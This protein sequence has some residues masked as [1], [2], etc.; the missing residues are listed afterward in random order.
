[1]AVLQDKLIPEAAESSSSMQ[2]E[3]KVIEESNQ[4]KMVRLSSIPIVLIIAFYSFATGVTGTAFNASGL[5][6]YFGKWGASITWITNG[7]LLGFIAS[8]ATQLYVSSVSD[9]MEGTYGRR[10]PFVLVGGVIYAVATFMILMPVGKDTSFI[11]FW[12]AI[13]MTVGQSASGMVSNP[14]ASWII[15]STV[16]SADYAFLT[17][18]VFPLAG[19]AGGFVGIFGLALPYVIAVVALVRAN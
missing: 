10:K 18:I 4:D 13:W 6:L 7:I 12:F 15:E 19:I 8:N 3:K 14:Y 5:L 1:M 17:S 11:N 9:K 16:D 2:I